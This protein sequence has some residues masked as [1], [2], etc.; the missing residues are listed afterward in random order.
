MTRPS[1]LVALMLASPMLPEML[2]E[3]KRAWAKEQRLR[4]TFYA[5]ITSE[6]KW[7]FIQG[8]VIMHS[9]AKNRELLATQR[10][11][12]L[13]N[14]WCVV[15]QLGEVRVEKAMTSFPR[16][17][18]E[19]DVVFFGVAKALVIEPVTL[20]FPVPDL[21]VEVLSESTEARDRGVK[22]E[23]YA[24]HGVGEYWI[25]DAELE[26]VEVYR[27]EGDWYPPVERQSEGMVDSEVI[28]GFSVPVR[29]LFG[30]TENLAA[31]RGL[32]EG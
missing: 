10:L 8:E 3:V 17:D 32:L 12:Q 24:R 29:A 19:P 2:Q 15:K 22:F 5:D 13:M 4:Q 16:N 31:L 11:F 28:A 30:E 27:L 7:E 26:T 6:H 1:D 21:I 20:R 18:Y 23:D 14:A 9:P 25:V